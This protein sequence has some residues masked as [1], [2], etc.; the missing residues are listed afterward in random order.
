MKNG[1]DNRM[2][3]TYKQDDVKSFLANFWYPLHEFDESL[4]FLS[5]VKQIFFWNDSKT[6]W[7]KVVE[8]HK[9]A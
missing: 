1:I 5:Q 6:L 8:L 3:P 2:N 7:W 4:F 9:R